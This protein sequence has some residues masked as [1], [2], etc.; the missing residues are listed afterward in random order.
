MKENTRYH[1]SQLRKGRVS[2]AQ[3]AYLVTACTVERKTTFKDFHCAQAA[4]ASFSARN[5]R[6]D[7][8]LLSWVLMPDHAHWV[9]QLGPDAP[10]G[11]VV[12]SIKS[13]SAREVNRRLRR[14]GAV[15]QPGFH[16]RLIR[17]DQDLLGVC[18]YVVANPLRAGL[19]QVIGDYPFWDAIWL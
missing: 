4:A 6:H 1:G 8:Q 9:V 3:Q 16:D 2:L 7:A 19:V 18:R 5:V 11:R 17:T 10:L 13:R 14:K 15:W 12:Q